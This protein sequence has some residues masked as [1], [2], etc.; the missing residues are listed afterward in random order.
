MPI[1]LSKLFRSWFANLPLRS[2]LTVPLVLITIGAIVLVGCLS[3][4][5][6]PVQTGGQI[7]LEDV[8]I[9][10][11]L[12]LLLPGVPLLLG[13][14]A[15]NYLTARLA[16]FNQMSQRW[17]TGNL[18]QRLPTDHA[19]VELNRLS[20]TLN[21]LAE[22][23]QHSCDRIKTSQQESETK[24]TTIFRANPDP[25]AIASLASGRILDANDSLLTF[26]GYASHEV[27]GRTALELNFWS[28]LTQYADYRAALQRQG[29]VRNLEVQ[30]QTRSGTVKTVLLSVEVR[31]LQGQD[32]LIVLHQDISDRKAAEQALQTSEA[33]Y[34]AIV[35]DQTELICRVLPDTTLL[36]V[37]NAYC[38]YFGVPQEELIGKSY[39]P[40]IVAADRDLVAERMR[41]L[42]ATNPTVVIEHRVVVNGTIRWNQWVN[43]LL[44][45]EQGNGTEIQAVGRDI[46]ELKQIE[47]ALRQ[48]DLRFRQLAEAVREGFFIFETESARYSYL[49]PACEAI[50]GVPLGPLQQEL[51]FAR[52]MSHWLENIHPDDRD[53]I[54]AA[55]Q[56]EREG[57]SFHQEYRF[58]HR[59]GGLRWLR[60]QAF[61]I[62]DDTGR[63]VRIV[64]TVEDITE[65]KQAEAALRHSEELFRRAF[66]DS[67]IGISLV[68]P[69]G[70][71][72]KANTYY[73]NLL[74]YTE[75]ELLSLTFQDLT[76]PADLSADLEGLRQLL[77]EEIRSFQMQ[78]RYITKQGLVVPV[79]LNAAL[80]R[81]QDGQPLY[82]V[83]QIQDLR[84]R[85]QAERMKDD[86]IAVVSHELRTPLTSIKGALDILASGVFDSK[87]E[88]ASR[89][90]KIATTNSDRLV[91]LVNDILTLERL[92]SGKVQLAMEPCEVTDLMQ[93][94]VDS[95][96]AIADQS[97]ITLSLTPLPVTLWANPDTV[98]Q[99]LI[100]LLGN[101]IK[102]S[103][104]GSTIWLKASLERL[105]EHGNWVNVSPPTH[106]LLAIRDQGRG[107]PPDKLES[108]F[109]EFQQVD[110]SDSRQQGGTGLGLSICKNIV[111]Q[112]GGRIWVESAVGQGSTFYVALPLERDERNQTNSD[113]R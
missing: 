46:T 110:A 15:V 47:E 43:R 41:S 83:G 6:Y 36:F 56:E 112:H 84:D 94:S 52:G 11:I 101:A 7:G 104:P 22:Q 49:N 100:N 85:L 82:V 17:L 67:P 19:I 20:Q 23:L 92:E 107:I 89:M 113:R 109:E 35:E 71:I 10:I 58:R 99:T 34:R 50:T 102:F 28:N 4:R 32:C 24:F 3:Y 25:M 68:S 77:A 78:K 87:P 72:C 33:R 74:G 60:S 27:M 39:N 37:N 12:S 40:L 91:R 5:S 66:D 73:C 38:R 70:Q 44:F 106:L 51:P 9:T 14:V 18:D 21:Q 30:M 53:R 42:S 103:S 16:Q 90:L 93:Q 111:Q 81:D 105:G 2:V 1:A 31:T 13:V 69:S 64:G 63:V 62:H 108:I 75:T 29:N 65:R 48:S 79:I 97:A 26:F 86:F 95:V 45:D 57:E 59:D 80:I 8:S 96:Q 55:L 98:I 88:K 54:E 76:H 61:P